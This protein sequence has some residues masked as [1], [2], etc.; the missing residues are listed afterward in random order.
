MTVTVTGPLD[1]PVVT[2]ILLEGGSLTPNTTYYARIMAGNGGASIT[3]NVYRS[4]LSDEINFTTS[5]SS[6]SARLEWTTPTGA[7]YYWIYL[8]TTS[9]S[10][11]GKAQTNYYSGQSASTITITA[12]AD[13][14]HGSNYYSLLWFW[15]DTNIPGN[16]NK[17]AG[18]ILVEISGTVTLQN[19][20]DAVVAAG[21]GENVFYDGD[22]FVIYGYIYANGSLTT[23]MAERS[24]T[25][26]FCEGTFLSSNANAIITLGQYD[27]TNMTGYDGC[28]MYTATDTYTFN[29]WSAGTFNFYGGI[30]SG[31]YSRGLRG[32]YAF[33]YPTIAGMTAGKLNIVGTVVSD[34]VYFN[35]AGTVLTDITGINILEGL[36]PSTVSGSF[37]RLTSIKGS[38]CPG[39]NSQ[40][41]YDC[42]IKNGTG[43]G[44]YGSDIRIGYSV[45]NQP[46]YYNLSVPLRTGN[47]PVIL[48]SQTNCVDFYYSLNL[49]VCDINNINIVDANIIITDNSGSP[50]VGSPFTTSSSG[51]MVSY[52]YSYR[53]SRVAAGSGQTD[54]TTSYGPHTIVISKPGYQTKTV[55]C[56]MDRKR[57]EKETLEYSTIFVDQEGAL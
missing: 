55:K 23:S 51:S 1:K 39:N 7:N 48:A 52:I 36:N 27:S 5:S 4:K 11:Y 16:L 25:I 44:Y 34:W 21:Y 17:Q 19:I 37:T 43:I 9:G 15:D 3:Q 24:K 32:D 49:T 54:T 20:Y 56:V 57:E 40:S 29:G 42:I 2:P 30:L 31:H 8:T 12:T 46:K 14:A 50:I 35:M 18:K 26:V 38:M 53:L 13:K 28:V 22:I 10:Y 45:P 6:L 33:S 47:I 41:F